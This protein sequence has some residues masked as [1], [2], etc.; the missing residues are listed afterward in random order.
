[1]KNQM[2]AQTGVPAKKANESGN[3]ATG[4]RQKFSAV[5]LLTIMVGPLERPKEQ[6]NGDNGV[7]KLAQPSKDNGAVVHNLEAQPVRVTYPT[8]LKYSTSSTRVYF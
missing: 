6:P 5:V 3:N 4:H 8:D 1:M 2:L 7:Q